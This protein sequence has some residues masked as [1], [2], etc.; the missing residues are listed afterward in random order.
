MYVILYG[1]FTPTKGLEVFHLKI[2]CSKFFILTADVCSPVTVA[3]DPDMVKLKD[4]K[5]IIIVFISDGG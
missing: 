1:C 5:V 2:P 4:I 3:T